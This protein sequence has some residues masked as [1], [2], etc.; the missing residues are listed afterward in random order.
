MLYEEHVSVTKTLVPQQQL[1][2]RTQL[3]LQ[4]E[5]L[6][7]WVQLAGDNGYVFDAPSKLEKCAEGMVNDS[8][9]LDQPDPCPLH[10]SFHKGTSNR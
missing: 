3:D 7:R 1:F 4:E 6:E 5:V 9:L 2:L 10:E 8:I